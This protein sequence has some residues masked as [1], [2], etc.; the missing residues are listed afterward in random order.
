MKSKQSRFEHFAALLMLVLTSLSCTWSLV[1][2]GPVAAPTT[3]PGSGAGPTATPVAL[4]ETTFT[5]SLPAPLNPGETLALGILDEVTGLGL[6]PQLYGMTSV[7]SLTYTVKLPLN[8]NS[9]IKYR[10]YR[11][12]SVAAIEDSVLGTVV[13]YRLYHVTGPGGSVDRI[14]S[15]TDTDFSGASGSLAG[16]VLDSTSGRPVPNILVNAGG[17]S[18]W[19]DSLGQFRIERLPVGTHTLLALAPDGMFTTFQQG[20][21]VAADLVTNAPVSIQPVPTVQVTFLVTL[22]ADTVLGAPVRLAG[23]LLQ[24]GN[25]FADLDGGLSTVATRMPT[26]SSGADDRQSITLTLP[27]GA[28]V[29]YK[30]TLGDGFWN[31]EHASDGAFVVRQLIIPAQDLVV[32]DTIATWSAGNSA[33]ILFQVTVPANTPLEETVSIQFNPY[34]WTESFPMWPLGGNQW[35]YKLYSP[36]NILGS[37]HYRYCRNDQCGSA[38]DIAT[39]ATKA[40]SRSVSTSL[41]GETLQDSVNAWAWWPESEPGTIIAVPITPRAG[42]FWAGV[43]FSP[44]YHPNWQ[45]LLPAAMQSVQALG[46]NYVILTPTWTASLA[47]PLVFAPTPGRDALWFDTLQAVQYAR[48]QN[49]S[50]ALFAAPRLLPS[51]TD[52]WMQAQRSPDWWNAWFERYRAFAL[53]HADL[54]NQAGAQT[55]I[56]GG[57][58]VMPALP[59]GLLAD[60]SP[61]GA[62]AEA[63]AKWRAILTEVRQ[64]FGGQVLWAHPYRG[65]LVPAPA[66]VDQVDAIYLLWS[67]PL[68]ADPAGQT[69][70]S[71]AAAA[72]ARLDGE[73]QPFLNAAGKGVVLALDYPSAQGAAQGCVSAGGSGCLD[74]QALARPNPDTP[75]AALDLQA[76][77]DLYQ[78]M[79]QAVNQRSWVGGFISRGYYPPAPLMDKSSSVRGKPAADLLWYWFPRLTGAVQ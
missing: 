74:W 7:D 27:V 21:A 69:T 64:R 18:T 16:V 10:Y 62:P 9:V 58:A 65:T 2:L 53:Y 31:A 11:Q 77:A 43:E 67:A 41:T 71:L 15:W 3:V 42:G 5:V 13:R 24:L 1:D 68:A 44:N 39:A 14:A 17:I 36:L 72:V 48:A 57:E 61:S 46:T 34:G 23:N 76:Q 38:D 56:L 50:V 28:D 20:A 26:L 40:D 45:A 4:A 78:A 51:T 35:V 6:N 37:F 8:L 54:A 66:F 70:E 73:V 59:G 19:T 52:F 22:P 60:G 33:P 29:R 12:G 49:L 25:T 32:E 47:N 75:S 79:L 63:E 55:L 30:Y